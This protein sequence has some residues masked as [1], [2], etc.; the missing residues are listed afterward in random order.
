MAFQG[1]VHERQVAHVYDVDQGEGRA[2]RD[3]V[4][5][6]DEKSPPQEK[7]NERHEDNSSHE[8]HV[9]LVTAGGQERN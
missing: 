5:H 8:E 4:N 3:D 6:A 1:K 9:I 2:P 7:Q